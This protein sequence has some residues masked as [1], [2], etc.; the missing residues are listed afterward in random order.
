MR[1]RGALIALAPLLLGLGACAPMPVDQAE[2]VCLRE[3]R[4]ATRPRAE[5]GFGVGSGGFR[6]G[7]VELGL[8]SDYVMGRDPADVFAACVRRRSGQSPERPLYEQPGWSA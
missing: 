6:G 3:T 4:D 1:G 2:R 7:Y 8:S 5:V